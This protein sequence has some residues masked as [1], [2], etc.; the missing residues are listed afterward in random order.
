VAAAALG[1]LSRQTLDRDQ[2]ASIDEPTDQSPDGAS[3]LHSILP[4]RAIVDGLVKYFFE[5]STISLLHPFLHRS[6]FS[7]NYTSLTAGRVYL[8]NDFVGLLAAMCA[9]ALQF[10]P[11]DF[12]GVRMH[13]HYNDARL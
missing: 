2:I 9:I 4:E 3:M 12:S 10:L 5:S 7:H 13:F 11:N 6:T 8:P 1:Q